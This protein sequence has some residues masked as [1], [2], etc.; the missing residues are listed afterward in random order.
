MR[1]WLF[2]MM[3]HASLPFVG[4]AARAENDRLELDGA[5]RER[6]LST[7]RQGLVSDEFWPSMHA[8]E[9]LS[10]AGQGS[11]VR[12]GLAQKS[13][14]DDQQRCGLA[15]EAVRAGD[16]SQIAKLIEIL[17][18]VESNGRIHA[19][20]S[21]F[22]IAEVG[23]GK[24][25]RAA[26][27]QDADLKLKLMAAAA[28]ARCGHPT[29]LVAVRRYVNHDD[30]D[31]RKTAAWILGQLGSPEDIGLLR[32]LMAR[33][34]DELARA[35]CQHAL[36]LLADGAGKM[37]LGENL[38][39]KSPLVRTYAAEFAGYCRG[40]EFRDRLVELLDDSTLDVRVRA[41]QS[42]LALT[43]PSGTLGLPVAVAREDISRDVYPATAAN[44]RYSEGSIA[45][46]KDGSLVYATTEFVGGGADHAAARIVARVSRD[47]GRTWSDARVLQE[48]TGKQNVM[49]VT[50]RRLSPGTYDGP[51]G[52]FYLIKNGSD[53]LKVWQRISTDEARSFGDPIL[54]TN[55][56][57]Y[58][59]MNNDRVSLLSS[60]RLICPIS[61]TDDVFK[62]GRGHFI[63]RCY[64][65][66]DGGQTWRRSSDQVDQPKRGAMEPEVVEL[67]DG[68]LLMIVRTQLGRIATSASTD[69]GDHWSAAGELPLQSPESPATI[70]RVP[71]TGDLLLIW[72]NV[73]AAGASHGGKRT[74]LT[75]AIS[76]DGGRSWQHVRNLEEDANQAYAYTSITFH[77]DR[78][79]LSYYV[80]DSTTGR[81]SS[82]FRSLPVSWF[83]ESQ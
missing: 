8:A 30:I 82:R 60:G 59:V 3:A 31:L 79:L 37:A 74:P 20:E 17:G 70:R 33:E 4:L 34:Q 67:E 44:P 42:L 63:S 72:N 39:S 49:S 57:G 75:A 32:S 24:L 73:Y 64:F 16:R 69:G 78:A 68:K 25:L 6:C 41:A 18:N 53:D 58:H 38:K 28:L 22:K 13:P 29:A 71:T 46:L 66:D 61:W 9:G 26:L 56:P 10:L 43:E 5:L 47:G 83:Y 2:V 51:L 23:D 62:A 48:N 40:V 27:A 21:L 81:I 11:E 1:L 19:A 54:V 55:G 65:S 15:R 52:M 7:L 35:Y 36:A 80:A 77:R 45:V 12:A 50:L 76:S 14:A